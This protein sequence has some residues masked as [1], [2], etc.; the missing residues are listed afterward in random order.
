[1]AMAFFGHMGVE[2]NLLKESDEALNKLG[3]WVAEY[4]KHRAWFAIDTCVHADIADPAVR[5]DGMVK[6]DRSAAFYR[7]TQL[8]TSQTLPAA[9]IR[10][11]GLDPDGTYRIQPLWLDLDLDGLGL[12]SGQSPLGWWTKDGALMT[13]RA[14]MTYGLRPPSLHPAQSVLFTAIRQ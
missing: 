6:P 8:T 9:P 7:F 3:E 2:W 5:V 1:M 10:V 14:L 4:K 13:G 11:P 12:G